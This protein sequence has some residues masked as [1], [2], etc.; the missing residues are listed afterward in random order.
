MD[1]RIKALQSRIFGFMVLL[2]VLICSACAPGGTASNTPTSL[3]PTPKSTSIA[4]QQPLTGPVTYVAIGAS[5]AVG[6]GSNQP[7]AQGYV[8]LIA[9]HLP[10]GSHLVNLG[11]S[12]IRVHEALTQ[13]LPIA[14]ATSPN[15]VTI[16]LVANDF[17]GGVSYDDYIH[18]LNTL[19]AQL[20]ANTHAQLFMANLPDLTRLPAFAKLSPTQK[21]QMQHQILHWNAG[22][23]MSATQYHITLVDLYS[24]GSQLT[25]HPEYISADGF[26]PSPSGYVQLS[27]IFWQAIS[28]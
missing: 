5:D 25:A 11:I 13:E 17:V 9:A 8:P 27:D 19:L 28:K 16:W 20:Q 4:H 6:V 15:L 2:V 1:T 14:L 7:D 22:I 26:H 21:A 3:P 10:K 12:G 18:D 23:A 24:H